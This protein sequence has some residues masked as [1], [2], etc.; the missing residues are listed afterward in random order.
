MLKYI[1]KAVEMYQV[2]Q[3]VQIHEAAP[4][5]P[6]DHAFLSGH[7]LLKN[8]QNLLFYEGNNIVGSRML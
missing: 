6:L 2:Q 8:N 3:A 7:R 1:I 5:K 4:V